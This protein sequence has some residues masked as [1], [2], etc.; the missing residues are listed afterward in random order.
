MT[1]P[2][3]F[4]GTTLS[5]AGFW[6]AVTRPGRAGRAWGYAF[7]LGLAIGVLAKGPVGVVLTLIPVGLWTLWKGGIRRV[8]NRLP[9]VS[10]FILAA[11]LSVPWY[12]LEEARTPGYL[13][14]FIV[15]EHWKRYT[16][17]GWKGDMFGT[18]HARPRGMIWLFALAVT[19]PWSGAWIALL[20]KRRQRPDMR[21]AV[22]DDG[23]DAYLWLWAL[24]PAVFFTFAGNVLWTYVLPGLPAFA[25]LVANAWSAAGE[26]RSRWL[27]MKAGAL[28]M[29]VGLL[30]GV[31]LIIPRVAPDH[32]Q[33]TLV[34]EYLA[35]RGSDAQRLVYFEE[36]PQSAQFYARGRVTTVTAALDLERFLH[37]GA[38]DF[39]VF[40][41]SKQDTLPGVRERLT[42]IARHGRYALFEEAPPRPESSP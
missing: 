25:L 33:K 41:D 39:F 1:D 14:Y 4:L 38:R 5:M 28:V 22:P 19:L 17:S 29:P 23:W 24:T 10:G 32:S 18:A 35:A 40:K 12:L 26:H 15:G 13:D 36:A 3:L 8:W 11:A 21:P 27:S 9:W 16:E 20:W 2:A 31:A 7:F 34:T 42:P 37:D 30:L 6:Q